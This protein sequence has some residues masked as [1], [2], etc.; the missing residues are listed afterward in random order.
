MVEALDRILAAEE[1]EASALVHDVLTREG[2]EVRTGAGAVGVTSERGTIVLTLGDGR[3]SK[4]GGC[5]SRP[6]GGPTCR[7]LGFGAVG[8]DESQR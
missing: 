2:I 6:D 4:D 5:W 8:I 1:P 3:K 7:A